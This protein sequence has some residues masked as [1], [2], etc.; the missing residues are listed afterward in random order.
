[1]Y[2]ISGSAFARVMCMRSSVFWLSTRGNMADVERNT[3]I[4]E[5]SHNL[6]ITE[7]QNTSIEVNGTPEK[8]TKEEPYSYGYSLSEY[9][10]LCLQY[11]HK[12]K[13]TLKRSECFLSLSLELPT[14]PCR[15]RIILLLNIYF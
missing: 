13:L 9:Y 1:M 2:H 5:N 3:E 10:K 14:V 4:S 11:Y 6:T 12:G 15:F 8:E 7:D